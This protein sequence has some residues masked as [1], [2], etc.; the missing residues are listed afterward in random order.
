MK[1]NLLVTLEGYED[2]ESLG[3]GWKSIG[4]GLK[5]A[6]KVAKKAGKVAMKAGKIVAPIASG[7]FGIPPGLVGKVMG[8]ISKIGAAGDKVSALAELTKEGLNPAMMTSL[9]TLTSANTPEGREQAA[10]AL[11]QKFPNMASQIDA[12][13]GNMNNTQNKVEANATAKAVKKINQSIA[14]RYHRRGFV[15]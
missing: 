14:E 15:K 6:G 4:R 11:K 5:K 2:D 13:A 12:Y 7:A 9:Y 1:E 3:W 10:E 8:G